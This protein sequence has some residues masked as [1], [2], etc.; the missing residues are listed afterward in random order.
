MDKTKI[1]SRDNYEPSSDIIV[2]I[3]D[4]LSPDQTR[5]IF[6]K[7]EYKLPLEKI[8]YKYL[9]DKLSPEMGFVLFKQLLNVI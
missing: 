4:K 8:A 2:D 3:N 5:N 7:P 6:S 1:K 9:K